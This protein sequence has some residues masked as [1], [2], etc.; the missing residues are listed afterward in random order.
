MADIITT[1]QDGVHIVRPHGRFI[2]GEETD[3]LDQALEKLEA[4]RADAAIVNL[5][6]VSYLGTPG[7]GTLV[8]AYTRFSRRH[9]RIVLCEVDHK[10]WNIFVITRLC[11]LF[12]SFPNERAALEALKADAKP[13]RNTR[14][15]VAETA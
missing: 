4:E 1:T 7:L 11:L 14:Q 2:G 15:P 3:H 9:A 5:R 8:K 6:E 12:E 10:I 13:V